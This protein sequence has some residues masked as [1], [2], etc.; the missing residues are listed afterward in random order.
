MGIVTVTAMLLDSAVDFID[1]SQCA[2]R[3]AD[4][5]GILLEAAIRTDCIV[6]KQNGLIPDRDKQCSKL[7]AKYSSDQL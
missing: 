5:A 7:A 6:L 3:P 4:Q 2:L 1:K